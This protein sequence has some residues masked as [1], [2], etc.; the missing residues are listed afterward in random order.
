[1][2]KLL[3]KCNNV[4]V[5]STHRHTYLLTDST[6]DKKKSNGITFFPNP[7]DD[8]KRGAT[9]ADKIWIGVV[10]DW[11]EQMKC[12]VT[13]ATSDRC[14]SPCLK[15][16]SQLMSSVLHTI[17]EASRLLFP[18]PPV[19][20]QQTQ[21]ARVWHRPARVLHPRR[22]A[23]LEARDQAAVRPVEAVSG[24]DCTVITEPWFNRLRC[25]F[26]RYLWLM[27]WLIASRWRF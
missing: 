17:S 5:T 10:I 23:D 20:L 3:K 19:L 12:T 2:G 1:M 21:R 6:W 15:G 14:A 13:A 22:H 18:R 9:V 27:S 4:T 16:N 11:F 8:H 7:E 24:G 25:L 26:N